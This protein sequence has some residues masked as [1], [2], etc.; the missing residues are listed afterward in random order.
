MYFVP[1]AYS[2][3]VPSKKRSV[4]LEKVS[5]IATTLENNN[6]ALVLTG[7]LGDVEENESPINLFDRLYIGF[8]GGSF[9]FSIK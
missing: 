4:V 2:I 1:A 5:R 9:S 7:C 6:P 8:G 3:A